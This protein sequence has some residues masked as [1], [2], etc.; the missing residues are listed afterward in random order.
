LVL[1]EYDYRDI[2]TPIMDYILEV[3]EKEIPDQI[4]TVLIPEFIPRSLLEKLL[5]N[6]TAN[7]LRSRL[8]AHQDIVIVDVPFHIS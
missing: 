4:T 8:R 6:Q 3:T 7:L 1:I 5:H 2:L